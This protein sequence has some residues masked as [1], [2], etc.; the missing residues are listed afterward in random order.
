MKHYII[1]LLSGVMAHIIT[2][3][4]LLLCNNYI[5][6]GELTAGIIINFL[7][8]SCI[9]IIIY[10]LGKYVKFKTQFVPYL[11]IILLGC[12]HIVSSIYVVHSNSVYDVNQG[13]Q[14][15][16]VFIYKP[17][18]TKHLFFMIVS[19]TILTLAKHFFKQTRL[20]N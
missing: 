9:Y 3:Y 15:L 11:S 18:L 7:I 5:C 8:L 10:A 13:F 12:I 20:L 4:H 1:T 6:I 14:V 2:N 16:N 17:V 19:L